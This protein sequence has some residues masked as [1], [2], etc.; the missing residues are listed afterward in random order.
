LEDQLIKHIVHGLDERSRIEKIFALAKRIEATLVE[1][2]A[3][4]KA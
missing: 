3:K 2:E 1:E 4:L